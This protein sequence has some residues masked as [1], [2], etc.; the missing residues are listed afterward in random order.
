MSQHFLLSAKARTLS[1][2]AVLRMTDEEAESVFREALS[3]NPVGAAAGQAHIGLAQALI[4]QKKIEEAAKELAA[5]LVSR[6][7][8]ANARME[9]AGELAELGKNDDALAELD[10]ASTGTPEN[11]RAL[12]LRVQI[13]F[14][15]KRKITQTRSMNSS[16]L[17]K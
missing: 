8:D 14:Q 13:A 3:L 16:S 2:S 5:Y 6:P 11:L 4:A 15:R 7:D 12:K 1:L 17:S 9:L 10:R